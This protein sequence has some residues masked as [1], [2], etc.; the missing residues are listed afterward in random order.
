MAALNHTKTCW[1]D[2]VSPLQTRRIIDVAR[3]V[4]DEL[5][6]EKRAFR[7][8]MTALGPP[9]LL[10]RHDATGSGETFLARPESLAAMRE[11]LSS[12]AADLVVGAENV[13]VILSA[14]TA[15]SSPHEEPC[16]AAPKLKRMHTRGLIRVAK[17]VRGAP[18]LSVRRLAFRACLAATVAGLLQ[19]DAGS[20]E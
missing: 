17:T 13:G 1:L 14:L 20:L 11:V 12:R 16:H 9:I 4:P 5:R 7:R 10:A 18:L 15:A 19:E 3:T 2:V 8:L 6:T